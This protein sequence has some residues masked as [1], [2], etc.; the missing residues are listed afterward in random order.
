L[1]GLRHI[2]LS[3]IR[4]EHLVGGRGSVK[5]LDL[6]HD[7]HAGSD[8]AEDHVAAVQPA[9]LDSADEE[10][11]TVGVWTGTAYRFGGGEWVRVGDGGNDWWVVVKK[12]I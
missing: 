4:D 2:N 1:D 11:A 9:G 5:L 3:R 10:L 12:L 7:V 8:L 6:P